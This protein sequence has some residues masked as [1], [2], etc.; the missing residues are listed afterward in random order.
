ME[1]FLIIII[2]YLIIFSMVCIVKVN[3]LEKR[4]KELE[5]NTE[6]NTR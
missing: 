4:I 2:I 3:E 6:N 5:S 1:E